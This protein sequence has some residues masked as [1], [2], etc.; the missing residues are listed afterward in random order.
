MCLCV[1]FEMA[2][3]A[4]PLMNDPMH[5]VGFVVER[6]EVNEAVLSRAVPTADLAELLGVCL[7]AFPHDHSSTHSLTHLLTYLTY[8]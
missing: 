7:C 3:L 8:I 4:G 5:G 6:I 1:G 2:C